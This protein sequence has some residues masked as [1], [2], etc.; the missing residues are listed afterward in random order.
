[1]SRPNNRPVRKT[2]YARPD[3]IRRWSQ[4]EEERYKN[5]GQDAEMHY[6][7]YEQIENTVNTRENRFVKYTLHVLGKKFREIF[8]EL[9]NLPKVMDAEERKMLEGYLITFK[10]METSSFSVKLVSLK[11]FAR[12]VAYCSSVQDMHKFTRHG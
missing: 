12:K 5:M 1:M 6:F 3:R 10:R 9:S 11:V 2:Y 7:R 4:R 8:G